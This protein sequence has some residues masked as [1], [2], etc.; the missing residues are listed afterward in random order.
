MSRG[1]VESVLYSKIIN[2]FLRSLFME[3]YLT[4]DNI[5]TAAPLFKI[6]VNEK[7]DET[8]HILNLIREVI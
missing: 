5:S 3:V 4:S 6:E 1:E 2:P 8:I 7:I